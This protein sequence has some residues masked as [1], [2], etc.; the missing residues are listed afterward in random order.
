M[1]AAAAVDGNPAT[2]WVPDGPNGELTTDLGKPV[3]VTKATPVW[4]GPAP[5]S[6][7]VELS[8][9][10]RHW[11]EAVAGGSRPMSARYVRVVVHGEPTAKSRTG[12]AELTIS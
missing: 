5:A 1:Y 7:D 12:I 3:R 10:G 2:A 11:R 9:D 4:S 8:V 6:Y